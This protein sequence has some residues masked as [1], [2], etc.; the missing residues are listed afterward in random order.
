MDILRYHKF[1][2]DPTRPMIQGCRYQYGPTASRELPA[3]MIFLGSGLEFAPKRK[4]AASYAAS[5]RGRDAK[6]RSFT[7]IHPDPM[8]QSTTV[9]LAYMGWMTD[10][11]MDFSVYRICQ[12]FTSRA[13]PASDILRLLPP[14]PYAQVQ[15]CDRP[16]LQRIL[17]LGFEWSI[18]LR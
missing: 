17:Q 16:C 18:I 14:E 15:W 11:W 9:S 7:Q 3:D 2:Q 4:G 5:S 8:Q 10:I 12:V 6:L 13:P 1:P